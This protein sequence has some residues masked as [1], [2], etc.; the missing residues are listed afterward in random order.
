MSVND[1]KKGK[2]VKRKKY[3][4]KG[5]RKKTTQMLGLDEE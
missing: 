4:R 2:K 1:F 5:R 3:K